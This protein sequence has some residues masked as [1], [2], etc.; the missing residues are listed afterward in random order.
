MVAPGRTG[1]LPFI[2]DTSRHSFALQIGIYWALHSRR[3]LAVVSVGMRW[4]S[5]REEALE[6][7]MS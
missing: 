4:L 7:E 1:D 3:S 6:D 5:A 2:P